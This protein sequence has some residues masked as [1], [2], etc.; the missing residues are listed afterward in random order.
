MTFLWLWIVPVEIERGIAVG[1]IWSEAAQ[2]LH[3]RLVEERFF[4]E[5]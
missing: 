1:L 5:D 2:I 3:W 4:D